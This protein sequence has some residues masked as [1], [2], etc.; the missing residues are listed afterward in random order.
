MS[1]IFARSPYF[2]ELTGS[3]ND[4]TAIELRIWNGTGA[5]PTDATYSLSKPIPSSVYTTVSYNIS[6][7]IREYLSFD[8]FQTTV[9]YNTNSQTD[10][11]QWCNV[12][13]K[14]YINDV[15]QTTT[16]YYAFDG[17]TKFTDGQNY[18]Q[19]T[20]H[21]D[22]GVYYYY[23]DSAG[24]LSTT[25]R[26]NAGS[27]QVISGSV[28]FTKCKYTNLDTAATA[29]TNLTNSQIRKFPMINPTYYGARVKTEVLDDTNT[30]L[31]TFY[32]YPKEECKYDVITVDFINRYG[33][34]QRTFLFKASKQSLSVKNTE[35]NG[36]VA[37]TDYSE[38]VGT[39]KSMN[40]TYEE[41]LSCNTG[42]VPELYSNTLIQLLNSERIMIYYKNEL[43][44]Y[45]QV[46]VKLKTKEV[47]PLKHLN[48]KLINYRIEFAFAFESLNNVQ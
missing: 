40:T 25:D 32:F 7:Y 35:Y 13:V 36:M 46:P 2:V 12:Q 27:I 14:T 39:K 3:A 47:E 33:S 44:V 6:P 19:G 43:G 21:L 17:W 31:K 10:S 16:T 26:I 45:D 9:N 20:I 37:D 18:D 30:V 5:A 8:D 22:E 11:D 23:Y 29:T 1:N 48:E 24:T 34:W 15:L 42:F 38:L 41:G 28:N 4:T